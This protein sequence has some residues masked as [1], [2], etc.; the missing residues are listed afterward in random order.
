MTAT[1]TDRAA[2]AASTPAIDEINAQMRVMKGT[3]D[4]PEAARHHDRR[5]AGLAEG[6]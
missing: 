3:L 5:H 6:P 2:A 1:K 4:E